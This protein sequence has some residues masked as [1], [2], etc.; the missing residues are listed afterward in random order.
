MLVIE[1]PDYHVGL[2]LGDRASPAMVAANAE[3]VITANGA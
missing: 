1:Q 3:S 2:L